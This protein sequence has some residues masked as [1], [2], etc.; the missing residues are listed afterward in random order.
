MDA[1][2]FDRETSQ[3]RALILALGTYGTEGLSPGEREP[4]IGKLLDLYRNDPDGGI[5]GAAE[6]PAAMGPAGEAQGGGYRVDEGQGPRRPPLVRQRPGTDL[7]RDRRPGRVSHG[8]AADR[9]GA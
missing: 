6:W 9:A 7:R 2:L 3:R 1:V 5:H 8:V 4:L